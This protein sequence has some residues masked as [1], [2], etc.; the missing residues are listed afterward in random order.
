MKWFDFLKNWFSKKPSTNGK[1]ATERTIMQGILMGVKHT[2]EIEL[3]CDEVY[4]LIDQY[5]DMISRG[6]DAAA[7]MP[8]VRAHL[9]HCIECREEYEALLKIIEDSPSK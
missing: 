8:L 9:D 6:E 5:V 3:V 1:A 4:E 2:E 7:M